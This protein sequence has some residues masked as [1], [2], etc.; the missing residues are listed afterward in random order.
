MSVCVRRPGLFHEYLACQSVGFHYI[1]AGFYICRRAV[2]HEAA[3]HV[4]DRYVLGTAHVDTAVGHDDADVG[5][6]VGNDALDAG[7]G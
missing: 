3:V 4:V 7:L 2:G 6:C 1:D 5:L